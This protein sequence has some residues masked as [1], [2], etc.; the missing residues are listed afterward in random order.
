MGVHALR[1]FTLDCLSTILNVIILNLS[2]F[3]TADVTD[4]MIKD[5][6]TN[7]LYTM[8]YSDSS[9]LKDRLARSRHFTRYNKILVDKFL[10]AFPALTLALT[11]TESGVSRM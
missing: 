4:M 11:I 9:R 8:T 6:I 10:I 2:H 7:S 1:Q 3:D 5:F